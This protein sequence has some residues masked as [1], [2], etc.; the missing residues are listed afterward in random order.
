MC[1]MSELVLSDLLPGIDLCYI[2]L[3]YL[4]VMQ[5][6]VVLFGG[7]TGSSGPLKPSSVGS[8]IPPHNT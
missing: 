4:I 7:G 3:N 6:F 5:I 2:Y 1:I 8:I